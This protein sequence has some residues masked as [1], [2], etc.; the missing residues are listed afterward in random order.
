MQRYN[1]IKII[2]INLFFALSLSFIA[3]ADSSGDIYYDEVTIPEPYDAFIAYKST[4]NAYFYVTFFKKE[5]LL[6]IE[7]KA[8]YYKLTASEEKSMQS[9]Y[10]NGLK[11]LINFLNGGQETERS[12]ISNSININKEK[13]FCYASNINLKVTEADTWKKH[14]YINGAIVEDEG[15]RP[16]TGIL[17][18]LK[19]FFQDMINFIKTL[20][21]FLAD[22]IVPSEN[23]MKQFQDDF[24]KKFGFIEDIKKVFEKFIGL[25]DESTLAKS[26][27]PEL[28][29]TLPERYGG[30][31]TVMNTDFAETN[32]DDIKAMLSA[33][34]WLTYGWILIKRLPSILKGVGM[35]TEEVS[36]HDT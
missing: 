23:F 16:D 18:E 28:Y 6:E 30:K 1:K 14:S 5:T 29:I 11:Q 33:F 13:T 21:K 35:I 3:N 34:F 36:K 19:G 24:L 9:Y 27:P 12:T 22:L 4:S 20:P 7:E 15:S 8:S 32:R 31:M 10:F 17:D 2:I 26:K 25:F